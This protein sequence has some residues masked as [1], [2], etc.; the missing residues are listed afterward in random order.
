MGLL[1][2]IPGSKGKNTSTVNMNPQNLKN[3]NQ[4]DQPTQ[5]MQPVNTKQDTKI[6]NG[7]I[8]NA[9][10]NT[11]IQNSTVNDYGTD[12][13]TKENQGV[14]NSLQNSVAQESLNSQGLVQQ[15]QDTTTLASDTSTDNN[16]SNMIFGS[17]VKE[18]TGNSASLSNTS[19]D[20]LTQEL[21]VGQ[22][23]SINQELQVKPS[24]NADNSNN[25][26]NDV[27]VQVLGSNDQ[28]ETISPVQAQPIEPKANVDEVKEKVSI[29]NTNLQNNIEPVEIINPV[30]QQPN[31]AIEPS[32]VDENQQVPDSPQ[33]KAL[34]SQPTQ[35]NKIEK[36]TNEGK[37]YFRKIAFLG[38]ENVN[39]EGIENI[40]GN[41][42]KRN[43]GLIIDSNK[44]SGEAVLN[45]SI[46]LNKKVTG[47]YLKPIIGLTNKSVDNLNESNSVSIIYSNYLE[48]LK[49]FVKDARL[50]VFF[51]L[52]SLSR[53]S[54]FSTL[55]ELN[56]I[57]IDK[58]K[59]IILV[60]KEHENIINNL[61]EMMGLSQEQRQEVHVIDS[62]NELEAKI[63]ELNIQYNENLKAYHIEKVV[64]R[65][66][67]GDERDFIIF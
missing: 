1:D 61:S 10:L 58:G 6:P 2:L 63:D 18:D 66:V 38:L 43:F 24:V 17:N 26:E 47:V 65:R 4:Q 22:T 5:S 37:K 23:Q 56:N 20:T 39:I 13:I 7:P 57:Y 31:I 16:Q 8:P 64:D 34:I 19:Q 32:K 11:S 3:Q 15:P 33:T 29:E 50:F 48:W 45:S 25:L 42:L 49:H 40:A 30:D 44:G 36:I 21:D 60:G 67:E 51:S 53:L 35:E 54:I 62:V 28:R 59:P 55:W 41:L 9:N 27:Q 52:N 14:T 46:K 12:T